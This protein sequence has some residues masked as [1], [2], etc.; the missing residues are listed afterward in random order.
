[1]VIV[2]MIAAMRFDPKL[3]WETPSAVNRIGDG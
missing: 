2:S 3:L 1:M